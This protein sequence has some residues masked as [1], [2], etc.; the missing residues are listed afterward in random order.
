MI[1]DSATILAVFQGAAALLTVLGLGAA[2]RSRRAAVD[3]G[4]FR[5][6]QRECGD[7]AKHAWTLER[8][9]YG[10]GMPV[11]ARPRLLEERYGPAFGSDGGGDGDGGGPTGSSGAGAPTPLP[12]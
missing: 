3:R 4:E 7:W 9:L 8:R 10:A 12:A 5:Q 11:P 2:T 6:L 1:W